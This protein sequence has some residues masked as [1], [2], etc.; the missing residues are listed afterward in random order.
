MFIL[1]FTSTYCNALTMI[2]Y[3]REP[4]LLNS[5]PNPLA[6]QAKPLGFKNKDLSRLTSVIPSLDMTPMIYYFQ[7]LVKKH[8]SLTF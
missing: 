3:V 4:K 7:I 8:F 1:M 6:S 2:S 5:T